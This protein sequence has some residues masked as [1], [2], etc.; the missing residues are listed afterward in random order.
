MQGE[1][2]T[3]GSETTEETLAEVLNACTAY[4]P[5]A[6]PWHCTCS[7]QAGHDGP[8][9]CNSR[10]GFEWTDDDP[11]HAYEAGDTEHGEVK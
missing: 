4:H 9:R 11:Q 2:I 3:T 8:H 6:L 7:R 5:K 10:C 1:P